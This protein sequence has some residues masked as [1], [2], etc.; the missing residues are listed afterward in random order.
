[1]TP[2]LVNQTTFSPGGNCF[3]ACIAS[4]LSM[5]IEDVPNLQ[6]DEPWR[7]YIDRV[8]EFLGSINLAYIEVKRSGFE[9]CASDRW[10]FHI[11]CGNGPRKRPSGQIIQHAVLGVSGRFYFDP[12]PSRDGLLPESAD[13]PYCF[14]FLIQRFGF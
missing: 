4:L 5:R 14:G 6:G 10:G 12:H 9:T 1:M 2:T 13:N 11:I 3:A 8:H 7:E